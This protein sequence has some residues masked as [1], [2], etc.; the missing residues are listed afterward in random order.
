MKVFKCMQKQEE[1]S[2]HYGRMEMCLT[3]QQENEE[4]SKQTMGTLI[5]MTGSSHYLSGMNF[6]INGLILHLKYTDWIINV[7]KPDPS[8]KNTSPTKIYIN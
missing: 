8:T 4:N 5:K 6:G 7:K 1:K 3:F 2:D